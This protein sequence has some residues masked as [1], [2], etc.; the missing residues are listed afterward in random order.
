MIAKF[1][2]ASIEELE[3]LSEIQRISF[4]ENVNL[5]RVNGIIFELS[6]PQQLYIRHLD[7][8]FYKLTINNHIIGG[9]YIRKIDYYTCE[10]YRLFVLPDFCHQGY[11]SFVLN[12]IFAIYKECNKFV[13][14]TPALLI[15]NI[16]FYEKNNFQKVGYSTDKDINLVKM[17]Y[18]I[19]RSAVTGITPSYG[20]LHLGHYNGNILPL[21]T[22][23][24]NYQCSFILAD[25]QV[26]NSNIEYY[27][28]K[29]L[30]ANMQ[31]IVKQLL[32][33]GVC[34]EKV[35]ILR[36]SKIKTDMLSDFILLT[37]FI[38]HNRIAR[39]PLIKNNNA[40]VKMSV[41]TYPLL[42]ALDLIS[43]NSD[44]VFSNN[45][46]RPCIELINELFRKINKANIKSYKCVKFIT[47]E[48]NY[49]SGTDGQKM[50]KSKHN[51]IFF[52][53]SLETLR[54]KIN[55]LPSNDDIKSSTVFNYLRA[56]TCKEEYQSYENLY[57][58]H[59][60]KDKELK[61][62]IYS[63][64]KVVFEEYIERFA[65]ISYNEVDDILN[66]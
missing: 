24:N 61:D 52:S 65:S 47:G 56:F 48:A 41:F 53:D 3:I 20:G 23:Q 22:N 30:K 64:L 7:L 19:V 14:E 54:K 25:W 18:S 51:C 36:E 59:K 6:T 38:T 43:T 55:I 60:I 28:D 62:I 13:L 33:L 4:A 40:N 10:I 16:C 21:I 11:G 8:D 46:N 66:I 57:T 58:N 35:K 50:S 44:L 12:Q 17:Q 31:L 1:T 42:Q 15:N 29:I 27:N 5:I 45:D 49:L 34:P 63:K 2:K 32:A 26:L 9:A 37:D 39:L